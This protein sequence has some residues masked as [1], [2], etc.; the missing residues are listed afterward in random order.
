MELVRL[1]SGGGAFGESS[2][3]V[4]RIAVGTES[5][6][7]GEVESVMKDASLAWRSGISRPGY[8]GGVMGEDVR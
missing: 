5:G 3:F 1:C 2:S 4:G 7:T 8:A 6:M